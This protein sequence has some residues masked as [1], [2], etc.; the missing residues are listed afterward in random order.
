VKEVLPCLEAVLRVDDDT[1]RKQ[2]VVL[3][4]DIFSDRK[5]IDPAHRP[6]THAFLQRLNDKVRQFSQYILLL[7]HTAHVCQSQEPSIRLV[8]C[9]KTLGVLLAHPEL[10]KSVEELL[11]ARLADHDESVRVAAARLVCGF[12][13]VHPESLHS[14]VMFFS[15]EVWEQSLT[16]EICKVVNELIARLR[17]K[18]VAVRADA[19]NQIGNCFAPSNERVLFSYCIPV[20]ANSMQHCPKNT[21]QV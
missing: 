18:K 21:D 4:G 2:A 20:Q 19:V 10:L 14:K 7:Q 12:G 5:P 6:L 8:M 1:A 9:E 17:D 13:A 3:L 16:L 15:W 11:P